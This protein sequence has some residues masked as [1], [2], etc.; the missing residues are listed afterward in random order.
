MDLKDFINSQQIALYIQNLPPQTTIDKVLFPPVSQF[1]TEIEFAKGSKQKPVALR[2]S[3]FDVAVKPRALNF[4]LDIK[5]KELPFYKESVGI[6]E[7][8]RQLLL[9]AKASNNQNLIESLVGQVYDNY[10]SLVDGAEV[11][12]IRSRAQLLQ[13][14]EINIIT[15]DGDIVVDYEVPDNHKEELLSTAMWSNPD[16]DIV[17]DIIRWQNKLVNDGYGKASTIL[18][19]DLTFGYILKNNAIRNELMARNIGAVIVTDQD[20]ISYLSTKLGLGVGIVNGTFIDEEGTVQNYYEDNFVTLI[21]SG[22]LGTTIYGTTPEAADKIYGS[23][24]IDTTIVNTGVAITTM[25]KEDPVVVD[26]KV[27]QLALPSFNRVDE[28]FFAHVAQ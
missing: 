13:H 15:P 20:I 24:K 21:P 3:T 7:A 22:T 4:S 11:Q 25:V 17:G 26:V 19:T 28:C 14:G 1:G 9:L 23:G 2:V 12:M 18:L 27:S 10:Q 6:K 8:D 5:K 16:P